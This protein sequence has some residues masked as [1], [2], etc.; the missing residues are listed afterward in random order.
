MFSFAVISQSMITA[1][2]LSDLLL[3]PESVTRNVVYAFFDLFTQALIV[4]SNFL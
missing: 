1:V 3:L 4:Y 2:M